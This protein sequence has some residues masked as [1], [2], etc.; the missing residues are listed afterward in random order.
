[1][2]TYIIRVH[3]ADHASKGPYDCTSGDPN[4]ITLCEALE[5]KWCQGE[6]EHLYPALHE[7][8]R[9]AEGMYVHTTWYSSDLSYREFHCG[10]ATAW[11]MSSNG[12]ICDSSVIEQGLCHWFGD[13]LALLSGAGYVVSAFR[14]TDRAGQRTVLHPE[15]FQVPFR[16]D[17]ATEIARCALNNRD[18]EAAWTQ[19]AAT[20]ADACTADCAQFAARAA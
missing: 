5:E 1:M 7:H 20:L 12:M 3:H 19:I 14:V 10:L 16:L 6:T 13:V 18:E 11:K 2:S 17:A 8:G 4:L 9:P 15:I